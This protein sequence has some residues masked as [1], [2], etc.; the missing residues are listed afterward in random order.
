MTLPQFRGARAN[1]LARN[2]KL[3]R[4]PRR[5]PPRRVDLLANM[6]ISPRSPAP[7]DMHAPFWQA[8]DGAHKRDRFAQTRW[9]ITSAISRAERPGFGAQTRV[10]CRRCAA[11][12]ECAH[13]RG[14]HTDPEQRQRK[15]PSDSLRAK[16]ACISHRPAS[17]VPERS[18]ALRRF[19]PAG[20]SVGNRAKY[21][22][23]QKPAQRR[24]RNRARASIRCRINKRY[25]FAEYCIHRGCGIRDQVHRP[26]VRSTKWLAG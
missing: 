13:K 20:C 12:D 8:S 14:G 21:M 2:S 19:R 18:R 26:A 23:P 4:K 25:G 6:R 11:G 9:T 24:P 16:R 7:A 3:S 15:P 17:E 5:G 1:R 10:V 22:R